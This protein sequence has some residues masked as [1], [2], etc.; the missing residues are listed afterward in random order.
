[1]PS[2]QRLHPATLWF[3]LVKHVRRFAIP[4]VLVLFGASRSSGGPDGMFGRIPDGWEVWLLALLVPAVAAS[5]LRYLTFR[6]LY[7]PNELV[8]RSGLFFRNERHVPFAKI[9]NLD[10]VQNVF[11]RLLGVVEIRVETGGGK[12][13]EARCAQL[14][15]MRR[16]VFEDDQ[17]GRSAA[18]A[19]RSGPT[20]ARRRGHRCCTPVPELLLCGFLGNKG[21]DLIGGVRCR[22]GVGLGMW[23]RLFGDGAA[24][25]GFFRDLARGFEEGQGVPLLAIGA[26][27]VMLAA[28]LL[29][30]RFVSM[31][32]AVLRLYDFRLS[33]VREDLR[34]EFGLLTRVTATI[35]IRRVQTITI[36]QGPIQRW[37]ARASVR[38]ETA[39]G[40][41]DPK[42]AGPS[43]REWLA[44]LIRV[45]ALP[46]LLDQIVPGFDPTAV[47][48]QPVHP[49]RGETEIATRRDLRCPVGDAVGWARSL[50]WLRS[51][52]SAG[53]ASASNAWRTR[54]N[55]GR[56][57][58][59]RRT[60][61]RAGK[62]IGRPHDRRSAGGNSAGRVDTSAPATSRRCRFQPGQAGRANRL[63][64]Q[65]AAPSDAGSDDEPD[66]ARVAAR[67]LITGHRT[68]S[69]SVWRRPFN[70]NHGD[71]HDWTVALGRAQRRVT[72]EA[73]LSRLVWEF[74]KGTGCARQAG[75]AAGVLI[76]RRG[77]GTL[78]AEAR[79]PAGNSLPTDF[80][81]PFSYNRAPVRSSTRTASAQG[82]LHCLE[83]GRA[84]CTRPR[85]KPRPRIFG[86]ASHPLIEVASSSTPA[87]APVRH[88]ARP[89]PRTRPG[90]APKWGAATSPVRPWFTARLR[91]P[92]ES[93]IRRRGLTI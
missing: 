30:V 19:G 82:Q 18:A 88:R 74:T 75:R 71:T 5:V 86:R 8:I 90:P 65:A 54:R 3:D 55:C 36:R 89:R 12:D 32:F 52:A 84:Y 77:W 87:P 24:S 83:T 73:R 4:A 40:G 59:W 48:W 66:V 91:L 63:A 6:L 79:A 45:A 33:R 1:M 70:R 81:D 23:N 43:D 80:E 58:I 50:R 2:E 31:A 21:N 67:D 56:V 76:L 44:P 93:R 16:R 61:A 27:L 29:M 41:A 51:G 17:A 13:E 20:S 57:T 39:G 46:G 85:P 62:S 47:A 26:G 22:V 60:L 25:R 14:T 10:A 11:H 15:K 49:R 37:L 64:A 34:I 38:V 72:G 69:G 92:K 9:Q 35:P 28:L 7:E 42:S 68:R 78:G 53:P